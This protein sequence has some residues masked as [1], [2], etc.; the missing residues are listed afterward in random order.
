MELSEHLFRRE[1][2]RIVATLTRIFGVH[3]LQLAEDAVQDAFCRAL[4]VWK[5]RGVPDNPSAWLMAAAKNRAVDILRRERTARTFA[6]ELTRFLE[7]E[8]TLV[9]TVQEQ[10]EPNAIKDD[11]LRMMFSCCHPEL[12]TEAQV[13]L[14]LKTLC[15]FGVSEIAHALLSSE[16][17]MEKRLGRARKT[18]R[19]SGSFVELTAADIPDRI[20]TVYEAIYLLFSEGYHGTGPKGI[21]QEEVCLEAIRLAGI[22]VEHPQGDKPKTHA[23]L[24]L[25]SFNAARLGGRMDDDGVLLQLEIQDR[26]KWNKTLIAKGLRHLE[27]SAT[28]NELSEFHLE[29]AITAAHCAAPTYEHTDWA[30][31]VDLYETLYRLKPSPIVALN[32]AIAIGKGSGPEEG[33]RALANIPD[34][35]R[36]KDYPFYPAARGEFHFLAGRPAEAA[37]H[38]EEAL[39]LARGRSEA[40]FFERK[41][42][43]CRL[44]AANKSR[45]S[46]VERLR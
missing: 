9:P 17:A 25:M 43:T 12:S 37:K 20:E 42:K 30:G 36:L 21:V 41:L 3:N 28:G 5:F 33:L 16:D 7:S 11:Q 44:S 8:W 32:R 22:L 2:G 1:A 4:E 24:A 14:I 18:L 26:S 27:K 35:A 6:P 19:L 39:K 34:A 10:F 13:S 23:L 46:G 15:G 45:N 38:F 29:A 40:D 31:I